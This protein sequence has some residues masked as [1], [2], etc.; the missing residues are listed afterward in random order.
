FNLI[1]GSKLSVK[2]LNLKMYW[3]EATLHIENAWSGLECV[4][5]HSPPLKSSRNCRLNQQSIQ[6]LSHFNGNCVQTDT[7][8]GPREKNGPKACYLTPLYIQWKFYR[9]SPV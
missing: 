2:W 6:L 1:P 4:A 7:R 5:A 8:S 9:Y 3:R